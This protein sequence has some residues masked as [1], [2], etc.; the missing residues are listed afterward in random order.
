[1]STINLDEVEDGFLVF[2]WKN[3]SPRDRIR[4]M[5]DS[6][7]TV[8]ILGAGASHHYALNA[9][10]VPVPLANGFFEAFHHLPTSDGFQAYVGPLISFLYHTRG[11][12]ANEVSQWT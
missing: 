6:P 5:A 10:G 4:I 9:R 12:K 7:R 1:M 2:S 3:L 8:W 11:I